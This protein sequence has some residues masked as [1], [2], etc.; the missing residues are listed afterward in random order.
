[1]PRGHEPVRPGWQALCLKIEGLHGGHSGNQALLERANAIILLDRLLLD[2]E[3]QS[4]FQ[5]ITAKGGREGG[6]MATAIAATA[7]AIIA[8]PDTKAAETV[9]AASTEKLKKE[10]SVREPNMSIAALHPPDLRAHPGQHLQCGRTG[11]AA[12]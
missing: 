2:L 8:V 10:Y 3:E 1:M 11:D 7:S 4:T 5:L 9:L 12:G 6:C